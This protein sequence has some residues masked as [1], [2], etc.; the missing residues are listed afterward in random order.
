[1]RSFLTLA[2]QRGKTPPR[3]ERS[4]LTNIAPVRRTLKRMN[5]MTS[6]LQPSFKQKSFKRMQSGAQIPAMKLSTGPR[7]IPLKKGYSK[8]NTMV[9]LGTVDDDFE[10]ETSS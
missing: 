2:Q 10:Y 7:G 9:A 1:V 4:S 6:T 5:T 8:M 3:S